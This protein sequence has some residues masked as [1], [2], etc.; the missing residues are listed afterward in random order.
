MA[1]TGIASFA[2]LP[3]VEDPVGAGADAVVLGVPYDAGIGF[4]PGTRFGPR[5]IRDMSTRYAFGEAGSSERGY[6][7]IET[8]ER[9]LDNVT[10]VDG[11]D[12]DILYLDTDYT[13]TRITTAVA[14]IVQSGAVPAVL[15]GDHS[16]TFPV[17]RG[18]EARGPFGL[19]H[20]D[21]HLDFK[22]TVAGV[23]LGNSSPIRRA[24]E[25]PFVTEI[26]SIGTRGIRTSEVDLAA[27]RARGNV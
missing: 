20:L 2:K 24:S 19:I 27:A 17:V 15:G 9:M 26:V 14:R 6:F 7:D 12:A 13:F 22:D 4:R 16:I 23:T 1:F 21:A 18:L 3:V 10:V 5:A 11:G 25:L 8:G